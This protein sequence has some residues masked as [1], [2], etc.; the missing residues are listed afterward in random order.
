METKRLRQIGWVTA[1]LG[2][3]TALVGCGEAPSQAA[4]ENGAALATTNGLAMINGLSLTNGLAMTNGL[5]SVN[6]LSLTNGLASVNGLATTNG[7]MTTSAG[8]STVSYLVR[9]AL[10]SGDTLVKADQTGTNYTFAGAMGLCPSWK[11]GDISGNYTCQE[12]LSSCMLAHVNTAGVH[13]PLWIV[14]PDPVGWGQ[15]TAYPNQEGT[16][17]GN[18]FRT[19]TVGHTDAYY[20]NGPGFNVDV[21]PGRLGATQVN[22]PYRN[23]FTSGYC[24]I[25]GCVAS[26]SRTGS[27]PDGYKACAMGDGAQSAWNSMLTVW[28]Q[29]KAYDANGAVIAGTT[30]DG[31][32]VRY[33]FEGDV[34]GWSSGNSQM[35]LSSVTEAGAQ[36]GTRSLKVSYGSGSST[37]R[38]QGPSG[39]S[40]AS[41]TKVSFYLYLASNSALTSINPFIKKSGGGNDSKVSNP[42]TNLLM[43]SWNV[44]TITVPSNFTGNQVG[45]E[46]QTNGAFSAYVDSVTW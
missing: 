7:L 21:V 37:L 11:S 28:R 27:V 2:L 23:M 46:F 22:A 3:T 5:A 24:N 18:I 36:T 4:A 29:N 1:S 25:N 39:L 10:A 16:F 33:D 30:A 41:G 42:G 44:V 12:L 6:G 31:R 45:V 15:N 40:L 32:T 17:F 9:C 43:G 34:N 19:N 26:D 14:G 8:R 38:I 35:V 20:C 13:I